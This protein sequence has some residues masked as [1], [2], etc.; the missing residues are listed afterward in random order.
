MIGALRKRFSSDGKDRRKLVAEMPDD[1][2]EPV[3]GYPAH[4][5]VNSYGTNP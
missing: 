5:R 1:E 3:D 4:G 2:T